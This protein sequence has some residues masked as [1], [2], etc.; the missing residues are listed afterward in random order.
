MA[1]FVL[2]RRLRRHGHE[3][4]PLTLTGFGDRNHLLTA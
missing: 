1:T 4:Y 2:A 3:A